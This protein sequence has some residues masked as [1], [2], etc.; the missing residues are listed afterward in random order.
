MDVVKLG[1]LTLVEDYF[2]LNLLK[3]N[4]LAKNIKFN[5]N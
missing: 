2:N 4:Q 5:K 1:E 3:I